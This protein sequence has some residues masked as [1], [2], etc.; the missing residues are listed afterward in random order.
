MLNGAHR[1]TLGIANLSGWMTAELFLQVLEHF[2]K[3]NSSSKENP[4]LLIFD[5]H[6]NHVLVEVIMMAQEAGV[7]ILTLP[8]HCSNKLQPLDVAVFGS[9]KAYYN[10]AYEAWLLN[11][12]GTPIIIYNIAELVGTAHD[13]A[14]VP[15]NIRSGFEK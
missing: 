4:S 7:N 6:E 3:Y 9:F 13:I 12:P 1:G 2:I 10:A 5:N 14:F 15:Q 11:H 8:P